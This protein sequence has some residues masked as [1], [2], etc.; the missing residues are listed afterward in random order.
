MH[1]FLFARWRRKDYKMF[2]MGHW[3]ILVVLLVVLLLFGANRIPEMAQGLGRGIREFRK[4]LHE[5]EQEI[6]QDAPGDLLASIGEAE[7]TT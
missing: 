4:S 2:G 3:E 7:K 5:V 1:L 6:D